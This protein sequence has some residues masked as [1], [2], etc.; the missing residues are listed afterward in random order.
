[1]HG[2]KGEIIFIDENTKKQASTI[3]Y[4]DN[5]IKNTNKISYIITV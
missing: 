4:V 2:Y 5:Q 1:M 3:Y